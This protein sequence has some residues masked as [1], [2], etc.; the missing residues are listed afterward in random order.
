MAIMGL[1]IPLL[2]ILL[3]ACSQQAEEILPISSK[4][5][6]DMNRFVGYYTAAT[7]HSSVMEEKEKQNLY[8]FFAV[9][10]YS[11]QY[12]F[13]YLDIAGYDEEIIL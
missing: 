7:K 6:E 1:T 3:T 13:K 8:T 5:Q 12:W 11:Y 9:A 4:S 10:A 2:P